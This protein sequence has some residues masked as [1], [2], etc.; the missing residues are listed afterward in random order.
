MKSCSSPDQMVDLSPEIS[1]LIACGSPTRPGGED[2]L[3]EA[4]GRVTDWDA[5]LKSAA[6]HRMMPLLHRSLVKMPELVPEA[7]FSRLR[8]EFFGNAKRNLLMANELLRLL[9]LLGERSIKAIPFKGPLLAFSVYGDLALRQFND[10]DIL[11]SRERVMDAVNILVSQGYVPVHSL[12]GARQRAFLSFQHHHALHHPLTGVDIEVHWRVSPRIYSF[13]LFAED[14]MARSEMI[15]LSS[16]R[17]LSPSPEDLLLILCH[18]GSRHYWRRLA[19]VSDIA[20]LISSREMDWRVLMERARGAG[21]TRTLLLGLSLAQSLLGARFPAAVE[22]MIQEDGM[23][24]RLSSEAVRSLFRSGSEEETGI[25]EELFYL[26]AR[27]RRR[28]R[29]RY[30]LA[31]A[32]L[33]TVEEWEAI[34]LPDALFPLYY[35]VR[36]IRL[37][38][39]YRSGILRWLAR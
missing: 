15:C 28:D 35:L 26:R 7:T 36:P 29:I 20:W 4:L 31:R 17:I 6:E 1:A 2:V 32:L 34:S 25:G 24:S 13:P 33:P 16:R 22:V 39:R 14:V 30:Y 12:S 3:R 8:E 18:H 23:L 21:S 37:I 10:L 27:E 38:D 11:V 19:W 5:L 9:E